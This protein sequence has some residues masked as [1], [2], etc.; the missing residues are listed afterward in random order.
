MLDIKI[1]YE[2]HQKVDDHKI[3]LYC[4]IT[5]DNKGFEKKHR[6]AFLL[7]EHCRKVF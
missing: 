2:F 7:L 4:D 1:S 5:I 3:L 6:L